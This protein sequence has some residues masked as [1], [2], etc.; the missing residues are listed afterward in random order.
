MHEGLGVLGNRYELL[1]LVGNGGMADVYKAHDKILDR[2]VAV[3]VLHSQYADD[4]SFVG[5]FK[6]EA[7]AAAK[8]S[9]PNIVNVYD[10]GQQEAAHYIVMEYV[11]G[12]TL[13]DRLRREGKIPVREALE[14]AKGIAEALRH[15]H[16]NGL[17]HCD[18]KPHNILMMAD[19]R[20]KVA[21]F[22]I[23]RA[24]SAA[25]ATYSG[26]VV[27]SV[28]YF[29]PEQAK[30]SAITPKSDVYSL[31]VVLYEMLTGEL[32][33]K[34][35]TPVAIALQHLQKEPKSVREI[36]P[37][38]PP[39]VEALV[40][41]MMQK[42]PARRP[43]SEAVLRQIEQDLALLTG[44]TTG[45]DP[46][47]TR[48]MPRVEMDEYGVTGRGD[49]YED[50]YEPVRA[51]RSIFRSKPFL[52]ALLAILFLG[53]FAGAFL[54]YGKFWS[55][56][57]VTVP[58]V[59][60][61]TLAV[62]KQNLEDKKLRVNIVEDYDSDVP[63]GQVISQDPEAG[64]VVKAE[65]TVT[66]TISK[67]GEEV[68]MPD[69][70]GL[71]RSAAETR[72]EKMGLKLGQVKEEFSSDKAGTVTAQDPRAGRKISKG[73]MVDLVLSKGE[74]KQ[75]TAVPNVEGSSEASAKAAIDRVGLKVGH[76]TEEISGEK[77]GTV[78]RQEPKG[79]TEVETG[80]TVDIFIS[81]GSKRSN[82]SN[83]KD[84]EDASSSSESDAAPSKGASGGKT[85]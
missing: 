33:F 44:K 65:R 27:G 83:A 5:R 57:E 10:V 51:E 8:M 24:V 28:H 18:I 78:I 25:T 56:E 7:Q 84:T 11:A 63:V 77:A 45:Y 82:S 30:G 61:Q 29:S 34:A 19:G 85:Q 20:I 43:D 69:L 35:D 38:L 72:I 76:V 32:P 53:F 4:A 17:V 13:K 68:T 23:A 22:G 12:D 31:G 37:S 46:Y 3:K 50:A 41:E 58:D 47:A 48:M 16:A 74:K 79:G 64:S 21:D 49:D 81:T 6:N 40:G 54:S 71:D 80:S 15:A 14:I 9:H 62:A 2:L 55:T 1:G 75:Q 52:I 26:D 73:Q 60:G 70:R 36:D 66:I 67:G 39:F 42:D 59:T